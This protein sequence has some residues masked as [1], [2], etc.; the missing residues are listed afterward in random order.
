[1][2]WEAHEGPL[3][4]VPA[5]S[6]YRRQFKT[7]YNLPGNRVCIDN[8]GV[9]YKI[10]KGPEHH[11]GIGGNELQFEYSTK[12]GVLYYDI[13]FVDCAKDLTYRWG[14]ANNCPSW[15]EGIQIQGPSNWG[16]KTLECHP[17]ETC[18]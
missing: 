11:G 3:I 15:A 8:C 9:T 1:M 12:S 5:R 16:C 7:S 18:M 13:S 4:K 6:P 2:A 10:T 14:D 17:Y